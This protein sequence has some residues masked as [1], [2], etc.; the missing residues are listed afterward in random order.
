MQLG[1]KSTSQD[2]VGS[3]IEG[4]L[5]PNLIRKNARLEKITASPQLAC[6]PPNNG[7]SEARW[8]LSRVSGDRNL[9]RGREEEVFLR[10][11]VGVAG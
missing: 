10:L 2:R 3:T 1:T 4:R 8:S 5:D 11:L 7:L 6:R 9:T